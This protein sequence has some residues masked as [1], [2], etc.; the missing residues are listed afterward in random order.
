M[1]YVVFFILKKFHVI[2][3]QYNRSNNPSGKYNITI[4]IFRFVK[5]IIRVA[6][7]HDQIATARWRT[8]GVIPKFGLQATLQRIDAD[9]RCCAVDSH[10]PARFIFVILLLLSK[11]LL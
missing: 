11:I 1:T 2:V 5:R 9:D 6:V 3:F 8:N 7:R 10:R 4:N